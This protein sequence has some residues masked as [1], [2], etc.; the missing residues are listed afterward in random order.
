MIKNKFN[1]FA[2]NIYSQFGEDGIIEEILSHLPRNKWCVEF[3][4]WDGVY[5]SNSFNIIKNHGYKSVLIE[6]DKKRF[7]ELRLNLSPYNAIL[8]NKYVNFEG[9]NTLDNL[10]SKTPI[11]QDFDFLSIDIDGCDYYIFESL[12]LYRPKLICIEYN[13][14]IPNSV[15]FIQEKNFE[16]QQGTSPKAIVELANLKGYELIASTHC[17]LFLL[18]AKY[19]ENLNLSMGQK[20]NDLRDDA[21]SKVYIFYGFDGTIFTNKKINLPWHDLDINHDHIQV[22]PAYIRRYPGVYNFPRKV[23]YLVY[24]ALYS[25]P[26]LKSTLKSFWKVRTTKRIESFDKTSINN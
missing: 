18:D 11:P 26:K 5:G 6:A 4:A 9:E 22:L 15:E 7:E 13:P 3:G 12:I 20:L 25:P 21:D 24:L 10:L 23:M 14:S 2:K 17:N 19:L 1:Q 8:L 16:I